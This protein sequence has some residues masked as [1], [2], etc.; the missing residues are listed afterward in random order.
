[1]SRFQINPRLRA[2]STAAIR[3]LTLRKTYELHPDCLIT[4]YWQENYDTFFGY[5]D[6]SPFGAH[7]QLLL[8]GRC[9][10]GSVRR[11]SRA[12]MEVGL[13]DLSQPRPRF[14]SLGTSTAWCW[15][16]GCRLQWY[17]DTGSRPQI[18][19]NIT[20][21]S[22]HQ[23]CIFDLETNREV[24]RLRRPLYAISSTG[25]H[26]VSLDFVRLQRLRPGYGYDDITEMCSNDAAPAIDGL[27]LVDLHTGNDRLLLSLKE[28][29]ALDPD[30]SMEGAMHYF[31]HVLWS[32]AGD[33]FFFMHL[34]QRS[35]GRR[36]NR[37][38]T[39]SLAT[40]QVSKIGPRRH[41]SHHCWLDNEHMV[42]YSN[43]PATG[44]NYHLY[45][46]SSRCLG[47]V[48]D[49]VLVKDGHPS[50]SPV[51]SRLMLTDTYP[52]RFGEQILLIFDLSSERLVEVAS[53][54]SPSNFR[55]EM[56]CDLHPRWSRSGKLLCVDS[57]HAGSRRLCVVN[58]AHLLDS[59]I[60]S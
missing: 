23:S 37:A 4:E 56:R 38:F 17:P 35:D 42:L 2:A 51:K 46:V 39:W 29:A 9:P 50:I 21:D 13:F 52:N 19:F 12:P 20:A 22:Y 5:H 36:F 58:V 8:A 40:S 14:E 54:Y 27:W 11:S 25:S 16:Q 49:G 33:R 53:L 1:V 43:E 41:V 3:W 28:I 7:D 26:G 31:N 24:N 15:Q 18:L 60:N 6:V 57:A 44:M 47:V 55:G 59:I 34:W 30:P 48:G 45:N 10:T 32:P